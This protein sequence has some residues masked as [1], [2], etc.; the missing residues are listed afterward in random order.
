MS[1]PSQN[2]VTQLLLD[3]RGGDRAAFDQLVPIVHRE[4]VRL[5]RHYMRGERDGHT[6]QTSALVNEAYIRLVDHTNID[7]QNRA[8]FFGVAAQAMRRVLV[9]HARSRGYQK[10]GGGKRAVN[11][12]DAALVAEERASELVA[13]DDAL[14][15]L[16]RFAPR[17]AQVVELR[18]FGGLT[19]EEIAE[20]LELS[21]ATVQREWQAAKLWLLRA[22]RASGSEAELGD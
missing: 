19:G 22:L 8:H 15:D 13:L 1:I 6:L 2:E 10:R 12:D 4:L 17:K 5:A 21:E 20:V 9:D 14:G 11:L 7:W 18:Y 16:E 3:W